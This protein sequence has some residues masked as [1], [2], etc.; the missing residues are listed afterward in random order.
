MNNPPLSE[1]QIVD[2]LKKHHEQR[3]LDR[4]REASEQRDKQLPAISQRIAREWMHDHKIME[5]L[6]QPLEHCKWVIKSLGTA[7]K[8]R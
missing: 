6:E 8:T 1:G 7:R 2:R 3:L 4:I 5:S